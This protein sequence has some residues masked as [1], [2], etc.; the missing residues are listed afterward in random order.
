VWN[1]V[2]DDSL[3]GTATTHDIRW[4]TTPITSA[5]WA[6]ATQVVGEPAPGTPGTGHSFQVRGLASQTTYYFA[7]RTQDDAGNLSALSNV[8][9]AT[10]R[11]GRRPARILNLAASF[12]WLSWSAGDDRPAAAD[13]TWR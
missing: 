8:P 12:V 3:S 5:N 1:A 4:S 6:S 7:I 13:R 11:D 9:S 10:T 2:G